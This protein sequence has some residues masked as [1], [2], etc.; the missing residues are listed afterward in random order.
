MADTLPTA[1]R[2]SD[3]GIRAL[4]RLE[5]RWQ[6]WL[7]V[8]VALAHAQAELGIIPAEAAEAIAAAARLELLDRSAHRRRLR[9]HRP[10][11]RAAGLGAGA[12]GRRAAWR[13]GALGRDDAEHHA[14]RRSAGAAPGARDLPAPDRRGAGRRW[15][16]WPSAGADMP[17][18]GRTHGQHAVPATFGYKVAVWIDELLRH[19]E[20]LQ[21]GGAAPVR[22]DARRRRRHLR[23][24]RQAGAAG[25][26][27]HRPPARHAAR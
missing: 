9:A 19:V 12:R 18:A 16:I 23:L 21:P 5:N 25:A 22:R 3:P 7:D 4:Y 26:G 2:V 11:A 15:P 24:A 13:L 1:T 17:M 10:H 14:D 27:R 20:R 8:E 6:A